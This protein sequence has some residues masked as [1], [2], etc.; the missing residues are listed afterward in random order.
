[1]VPWSEVPTTPMNNSQ[2]P[3]SNQILESIPALPHPE[4]SKIFFHRIMAELSQLKEE[5]GDFTA[6]DI[7]FKALDTV[8]DLELEWA[9]PKLYG[10]NKL[11]ITTKN[12]VAVLDVTPVIQAIKLVWNTYIQS[13]HLQ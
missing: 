11:L 6:K 1:M 8:P 9:D 3:N 5:I 7:V 12:K 13:Q 2:I 10:K 4:L